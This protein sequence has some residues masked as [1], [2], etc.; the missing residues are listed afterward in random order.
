MAKGFQFDICSIIL[1]I[2]HC[3]IHEEK[4]GIELKKY[5]NGPLYPYSDYIQIKAIKADK[6]THEEK[7]M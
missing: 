1:K 5:C 4:P 2:G 7:H 3:V 6:T